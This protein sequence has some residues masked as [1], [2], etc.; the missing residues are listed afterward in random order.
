MTILAFVV[1]ALIPSLVV[2]VA[3]VAL[4]TYRVAREHAAAARA[5]HVIAERG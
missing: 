4:A 2:L 1:A 3:G 5:S